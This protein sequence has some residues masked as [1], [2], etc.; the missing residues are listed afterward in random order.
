MTTSMSRTLNAT[1]AHSVG[2]SFHC[3]VPGGLSGVRVLHLAPRCLVLQRKQQPAGNSYKNLLLPRP[4]RRDTGEY[5]PVQT[6]YRISN[7]FSFKIPVV[8]LL[9]KLRLIFDHRASWF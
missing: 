3:G 2:S 7:V 6:T 5:S 9:I 8:L 4:F 1:K